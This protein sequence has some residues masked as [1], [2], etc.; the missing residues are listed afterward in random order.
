[1]TDQP[2]DL[3]PLWAVYLLIVLI[4]LAA[5]EAGFQLTQTMQ[6][7]KPAKTDAGVGAI[8]GA[9]L[10]LLA[11][12]LAFVVSFAVNI[13]NE[14]RVL[15]I[16]EANAI[17]TAYLRAGYLDEP[18]R[19]ESRALLSEYVNLRL[20]VLDPEMAVAR[21]EEIHNELWQGAEALAREFPLATIALYVSSLNDVID[22]H[23]ER[24][25]VGLGIRVPPTVLLGL[26]AVALFTM[27]L[28][29]MQ[30]GYAENRNLIALVMLVLILSVVFLLIVD[31][32]RAREGLLQVPQQAMFDLQRQ[33]KP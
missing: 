4:M 25:S 17:G 24:V 18:Y 16:K 19:A 33:L 23:T 27:F 1:M 31:L 32:D 6:R 15:V 20:A 26:C 29:G 3:L 10:A 12:L 28:V 2:L 30:S 14:R 9:T 13:F 5:I 21:S 22:V 7:R 11:F 8:A